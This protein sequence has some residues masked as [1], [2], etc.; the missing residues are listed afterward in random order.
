[1]RFINWSNAVIYN[2]QLHQAVAYSSSSTAPANSR[3]TH[4]LPRHSHAC[5][6]W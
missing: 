6:S 5:S 3:L 4:L 2:M 1:M